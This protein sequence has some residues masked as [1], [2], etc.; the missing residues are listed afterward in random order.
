MLRLT[1]PDDEAGAGVETGGAEGE[2][3]EPPQDG[4]SSAIRKRQWARL[5]CVV[6]E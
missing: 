3:E 2:L 1:A 6:N 4:R 5:G